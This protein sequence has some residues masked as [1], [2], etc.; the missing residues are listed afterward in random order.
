MN[1]LPPIPSVAS[2][3]GLSP[4]EVSERVLEATPP[5]YREVIGA[6]LDSASLHYHQLALPRLLSDLRMYRQ[7]SEIH[8][9]I[10]V[11]R[12]LAAFSI[13]DPE[14]EGWT[15]ALYQLSDRA[16]GQESLPREL[17][18][19]RLSLDLQLLLALIRV[20]G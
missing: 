7:I 10:C 4:R 15:H 19:S 3:R 11:Q 17:K 18:G 12:I 13:E 5:A 14:E 8:A 2:L 16:L 20:A 9:K 6:Q 1:E